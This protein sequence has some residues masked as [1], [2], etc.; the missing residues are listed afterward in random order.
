MSKKTLLRVVQDYLTYVDGFPVDSIFDSEESQQAALIAEH[1][2]DTVVDK[3]NDLAFQTVVRSLDASG[4]NTRPSVL[5]I[6]SEIR[7]IHSSEIWYNTADTPTGVEWKAIKY[8]RPEDFLKLADM[9]FYDNE[10]N[11]QIMVVNGTE[12]VIRNDKSPDYCTSFDQQELIFDSFDSDIDTTLQESRTKVIATQAPVFLIEDDFEIPLPERMHSGY[13]DLVI[14]EC[15][16]ALR[17][18]TIGT[19]SRRAN[20]FVAKMQQSQRTVGGK[21]YSQ[22]KYGRR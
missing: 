13:T 17:S 5:L 11:K 21:L 6:P 20:Q 4:D 14:Q 9:Q 16:S 8:L 19:V 10:S 2:F 15:C 18:M 22:K 1:V 12:F 7:R 3:N